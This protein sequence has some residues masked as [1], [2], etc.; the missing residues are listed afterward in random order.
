MPLYGS[1]LETGTG[2]TLDEA[3]ALGLADGQ[4]SDHDIGGHRPEHD[5]QVPLG[6]HDRGLGVVVSTAH[7]IGQVAGVLVVLVGLDLSILAVVRDQQNLHLVVV[8]RLAGD[9][10]EGVG[11]GLHADAVVDDAG[12]LVLLVHGL[13]HAV[14]GVHDLQDEGR[15]RNAEVAVR[16]V[17][18]VLQL[19][20]RLVH[21]GDELALQPLEVA[22]GKVGGSL[23]GELTLVDMAGIQALLQTLIL[24]ARADHADILGHRGH[25]VDLGKVLDGVLDVGAGLL[26]QAHLDVGPG[27]NHELLEAVLEACVDGVGVLAVVHGGIEVNLP[28]AGI[29][30]Q[31]LQHAG[32]EVDPG[33]EVQRHGGAVGLLNVEQA[34]QGVV[35]G[36]EVGHGAPGEADLGGIHKGAAFIEG[37]VDAGHADVAVDLEQR[38]LAGQ[39][40]QVVAGLG[41]IN[42]VHQ[43]IHHDLGAIHEGDAGIGCQSV[44]HILLDLIIGALDG[45]NDL[46]DVHGLLLQGLGVEQTV[47]GGLIGS[48]HHGRDAGGQGDQ[49]GHQRRLGQGGLGLGDV[50]LEHLSDVLSILFQELLQHRVAVYAGIVLVHQIPDRI[51]HVL[52]FQAGNGVARNRLVADRGGA[53]LQLIDNARNVAALRNAAKQYAHKSKLLSHSFSD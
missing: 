44:D 3:R 24:H 47:E 50:V 7:L 18:L 11:A 32:I 36:A 33:G 43:G 8:H 2:D 5:G 53:L 34:G 9:E 22:I 21:E 39:K 13:V 40:R 4:L 25:D 37:D 49:V 12:A 29:R 20:G 46:F 51:G 27:R 52:D 28:D 19:Q 23:E 1:A 41:G 10:V 6:V 42:A 15:H 14:V 35:L 38:V 30:A 26:R 16:D 48:P 31:E 45:R 17:V